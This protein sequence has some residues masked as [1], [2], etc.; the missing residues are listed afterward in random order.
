MVRRAQKGFTLIELMIVVAIV[1]ILAAIAIPAYQDYTVR[2][3]VTEGLNLA[4][5]AKMVVADAFE[6]NG[7][8][9]VKS[10]SSQWTFTATKYVSNITIDA[11]DGSI[12]VK[13]LSPVQLTGNVIT[14]TPQVQVAGAY[15]LLNAVGTN[16]GNIDWGCASTADTTMTSATP[17]LGVGAAG[18]GTVPARYVP[19]QCR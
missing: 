10:A 16:T 14:L 4:D 11:A 6:S 15:A 5:A 19:H 3:K 12:A 9:G 1:G 2:A 17:P 18:L 8:Q 13:Y 7:T